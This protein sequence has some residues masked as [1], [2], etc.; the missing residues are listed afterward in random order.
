MTTD[1]PYRE[2]G[3]MMVTALR[4]LPDHREVAGRLSNLVL[5]LRPWPPWRH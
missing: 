3:W 2:V 4:A 1:G 5:I